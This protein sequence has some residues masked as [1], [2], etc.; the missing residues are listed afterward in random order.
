M[1]IKVKE[2]SQCRR[3]LEISMPP[4]VVK[5]KTTELY[6]RYQ[7]N[8]RIDGFRRGK[9]PLD[10]IKSKY[11]KAIE[12]EAID[13]TI[14]EAFKNA[15]K[16]KGLNPIT[17][18]IA[19]D[20]KFSVETGLSVKITFEVAPDIKIKNYKGIEIKPYPTEVSEKEIESV[21]LK[22]QDSKA[23]Y[24]PVFTRRARIDDM[25][26]VDYDIL[27]EERGIIRKDKAH[28]YTIILGAPEVPEEVTKSLINS[29]VD[30]RK[31][32]SLRYPTDYKDANLRGQSVEY[33]FVVREIKEKQLPPID[34]EFVKG[35][36]FKSLVD[37]KSNV[38]QE[39]KKEKHKESNIKAET[40]IL[41]SLI[42]DTPFEP[43]SS[44]VASYLQPLLKQVE[45]EMKKDGTK[46][47]DAETKKALE[48]I[49]IWRA[50]REILLDKICEIEKIEMTEPEIKSKFME[51]DEYR[52]KGYEKVVKSLK[53]KGTYDW[54]IGELKR[55]K[56]MDLLIS[57]TNKGV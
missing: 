38:E 26:I 40:Q 21:L 33:E 20:T 14:S 12:Q 51:V 17:Q 30:D 11:G 41:N 32:V 44:I 39:L 16:E 48:E 50:K 34:D 31:K 19:E 6:D 9:V 54:L 15:I 46:E 7:K 2:I 24:I 10:V 52:Q 13:F 49:A 43:P 47:M 4:D 29:L 55:E 37:L 3:E 22:I 8:L 35:V 36:G 53:E 56:A 42:Q 45:K 25:L 18:G 5:A 27:H 23:I 28:S 1:D 57:Y